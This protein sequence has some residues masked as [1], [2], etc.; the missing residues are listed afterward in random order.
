MAAGAP[1]ASR[2]L[3]AALPPW[4]WSTAPTAHRCPPPPTD[5]Y[6]FNFNVDHHASA[7]I[8]LLPGQDLAGCLAITTRGERAVG[9]GGRA[10]TH[11]P[12]HHAGCAVR[13]ARKA[14]PGSP[15]GGPGVTVVR[16]C[17]CLHVAARQGAAPST[18]VATP[19]CS[20]HVLHDVAVTGPRA[21]GT[22]HLLHS[23]P[24]HTPQGTPGLP[25]SAR[26]RPQQWARFAAR[27]T[28][29]DQPHRAQA[30]AVLTFAGGALPPPPA[31]PPRPP[32]SSSPAIACQGARVPCRTEQGCRCCRGTHHH[33]IHTGCL[34]A[35]AGGGPR[36]LAP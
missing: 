30:R 4:C 8:G 12:Q 32:T 15:L 14:V 21:A 5:L 6:V 31:P 22:R 29:V 17:L 19:K 2:L 16:P 3:Q 25:S 34:K 11:T 18:Q 9:V 33:T 27:T 10:I 7:A 13:K 35:V 36:A 24:S 23:T 26:P 20:L 1:P 28:T